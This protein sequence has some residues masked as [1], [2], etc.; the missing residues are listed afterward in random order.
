MATKQ[1]R[2][3][4]WGRTLVLLGVA[5]WVP[6]ALLEYGLGEDIPFTP[7]LAAHLAGVLPGAL[8]ARGEQLKRGLR[9]LRARVVDG[10]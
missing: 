7:F 6:Y 10:P 1:R 4:R 3:E 5:A 2:R 9:R 8:L